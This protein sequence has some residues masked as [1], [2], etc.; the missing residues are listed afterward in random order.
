[1]HMHNRNI[2]TKSV[3]Q[4]QFGSSLFGGTE[5]RLLLRNIGCSFEFGS[6]EESFDWACSPGSASVCSLGS[7]WVVTLSALGR[8]IRSRQLRRI[9]SLL[10]STKYD[11]GATSLCT[12]PSLCLCGIH[13]WSPGLSGGSSLAP[14][15]ESWFLFCLVLLCFSLEL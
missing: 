7:E 9:V 8:R 12:S 2:H 15:C 5:F 3:H 6:L 10:Y 13:T 14:W 4:V 1:M 11:C